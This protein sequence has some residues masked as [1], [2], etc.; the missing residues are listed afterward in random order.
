MTLTKYT[1][2]GNS[3]RLIV[4]AAWPGIVWISTPVNERGSTEL[5]SSDIS[6]ETVSVAGF[7]KMFQEIVVAFAS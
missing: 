2:A 3:A 5:I 6:I 7:G 4:Y 1:P